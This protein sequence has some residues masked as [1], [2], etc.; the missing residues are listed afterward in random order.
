MSAQVVIGNRT[1]TSQDIPLNKLIISEV[2]IREVQKEHEKYAEMMSSIGQYGVLQPI[3]V[4]PSKDFPEMFEIC[5]GWQ[6]TNVSTD[7]N[8]PTIPAIIGDFSD[9]EIMLLQ[10]NLN[11]ARIPTSVRD[12]AFHIIKYAGKHPEK[13]QASIAAEFSVNQATV[14]Q[15]LKLTDLT[16]T[17]MK[18]VTEGEV[19]LV[20]AT[21]L[22][23][24]PQRFQEQHLDEAK[25][26]PSTT[27]LPHAKT[28]R[29]EYLAAIKEG[30]DPSTVERYY[31]CGREEIIHSYKLAKMELDRTQPGNENYVKLGSRVTTLQEVLGIDAA[32][33][34]RRN[35]EKE[36]KKLEMAT[37]RHQKQEEAYA[38]AKTELARQKA[39][40]KTENKVEELAA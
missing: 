4:R 30:V 25:S 10:Y 27:F 24:I 26:E 35:A 21:A 23:K 6:R 19:S 11:E 20:N 28:L 3:V 17:C 22:A 1:Y 5:D 34:A 14:S 31:P 37:K 12:K 29:K 33:I 18:A 32:S 2:K 16:E 38:K 40:L 7:L 39:A 13:T 15:L 8:R 36:I 9:D